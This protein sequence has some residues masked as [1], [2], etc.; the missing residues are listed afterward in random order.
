MQSA[1]NKY[2]MGQFPK[3]SKTNILKYLVYS[4]YLR[5]VIIFTIIINNLVFEIFI[6]LCYKFFA[7]FFPRG[8]QKRGDQFDSYIY[9]I[10]KR[11]YV[12]L[13]IFRSKT[14]CDRLRKF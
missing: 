2:V 13:L 8:T 4:G 12:I 14:F 10:S 1:D 9:F 3:L 6:L 11:S 5:N 7:Y